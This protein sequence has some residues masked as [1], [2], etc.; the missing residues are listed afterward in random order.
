MIDQKKTPS[1]LTNREGDNKILISKPTKPTQFPQEPLLWQ[2]H[3]ECVGRAGDNPSPVN[4]IV[5]QIIA[6]EWNETCK[7][8][9]FS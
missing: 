9:V 4:L 3:R 1:G 6:R 7:H 2:A 5:A 8:E